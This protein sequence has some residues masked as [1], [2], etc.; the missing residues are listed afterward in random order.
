[1]V[2]NPPAMQEAQDLRFQFL[3]WEG[4]LEEEMA[5]HCSIILAWRIPRTEE[6]GSLQSTGSHRVEHNWSNLAEHTRH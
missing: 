1:M 3:G 4:T 6:P 5:T 2:K